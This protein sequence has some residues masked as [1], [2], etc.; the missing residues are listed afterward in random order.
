MST[1]GGNFSK[2]LKNFLKIKEMQKRH[3]R[4]RMDTKIEGFKSLFL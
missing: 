2:W 3:E 1:K 4:V